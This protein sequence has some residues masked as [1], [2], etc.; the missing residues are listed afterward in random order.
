MVV[1]VFAGVAVLGLLGS[2]AV[3]RLLHAHLRRVLTDICET[4]AR[5]G[6]FVA[7]V[8]LTIVLSGALA[9]TATSGYPD[10]NAVGF[11]LLSGALTQTRTVMAG[12]LGV[13]LVVAFLLVGAIRRYENLHRRLPPQAQDAMPPAHSRYAPAPTSPGPASQAH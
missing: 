12:L 8:G 13:V 10:P 1:A 3:E 6:F 9:S 11:D 2:F 4:D 5:S 7:V